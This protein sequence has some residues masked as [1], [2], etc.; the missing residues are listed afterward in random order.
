MG[1]RRRG[2][3]HTASPTSSAS[4]STS[5]SASASE[6]LGLR[7]KEAWPATW[8][9]PPPTTTTTINSSSSSPSAP[10]TPPTP[11]TIIIT[12]T[13]ITCI[14]SRDWGLPA[15]PPIITELR[16]RIP[17]HRGSPPFLHI[18]FI[19]TIIIIIITII[20][21]TI[22]HFGISC[23]TIHHFLAFII[24]FSL[25]LSLSLFL[26]FSFS[27]IFFFLI[28]EYFFYFEREF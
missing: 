16:R 23:L 25:S 13:I 5:T 10:W 6:L 19:I 27:L 3:V 14:S 18:C 15:L 22:I 8:R 28:G 20:I 2:R 4:A 1:D 7:R 11:P 24:T 17:H 26:S 21:I 9:R 12:T